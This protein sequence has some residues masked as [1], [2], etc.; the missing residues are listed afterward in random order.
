MKHEHIATLAFDFPLTVRLHRALIT[1]PIA[2]PMKRLKLTPEGVDNIIGIILSDE[3]LLDYVLHLVNKRLSNEMK[4]DTTWRNQVIDLSIE[5]V[6][7]EVNVGELISAISGNKHLQ[8][9]SDRSNNRKSRD[10]AAEPELLKPHFSSTEPHAATIMS[11]RRMV[12]ELNK[13]KLPHQDDSPVHST[14]KPVRSRVPIPGAYD[15]TTSV[16]SDAS[17][18]PVTTAPHSGMIIAMNQ[19]TQESADWQDSPFRDVRCESSMSSSDDNDLYV[20]HVA[21]A[22]G[23]FRG[24]SVDEA[25]KGRRWIDTVQERAPIDSISEADSL[26]EEETP[27]EQ[28]VGPQRADVTKKF[29]SQP[30]PS[31]NLKASSSSPSDTKSANVSRNSESVTTPRESG[32]SDDDFLNSWEKQVL[33]G[34]KTGDESVGDE[35]LT[36]T[37]KLDESDFRSRNAMRRSRSSS[38]EAVEVGAETRSRSHSDSS[39]S[40]ANTSEA[41]SEKLAH[42]LQHQH[43]VHTQRV[44]SRSGDEGEEYSSDEHAS[45]SGEENLN[46]EYFH[47]SAVAK[48]GQL[49]FFDQ[50]RFDA[51]ADYFSAVSAQGKKNGEKSPT[52]SSPGK[53]NKKS[54]TK[55]PNQH[56]RFAPTLISEVRYRDRVGYHEKSELFF[57]HNEEYQFTL[58][59]SKEAERAEAVGMTWMEWMDQRTDE[60]VQREE[61][62]EANSL[63]DFKLYSGEYYEED[64]DHHSGGFGDSNSWST[65]TTQGGS[66]GQGNQDAKSANSHAHTATPAHYND[67]S[68]AGMTVHPHKTGATQNNVPAPEVFNDELSVPSCSDDDDEYDFDNF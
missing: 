30:A 2:Q 5:Q 62:E 52:K 49:L 48:T 44:D 36:P 35:E 43:K 9:A 41:A 33:R 46:D 1:F 12:K 21:S 55:D 28:Y 67:S 16:E 39:A 11:P 15:R 18:I 29:S 68:H 61:N 26:E 6:L 37:A 58:D 63:G 3:S 27:R 56:V 50:S 8:T 38:S 66:H 10:V 22:N 34:M 32:V 59:Q 31:H 7:R 23:S 54:R 64:E 53:K 19:G 60:D 14:N 24:N 4:S 45:E 57:T 51:D 25:R 42:E 40:S 47:P 13:N 17:T 65:S 20:S